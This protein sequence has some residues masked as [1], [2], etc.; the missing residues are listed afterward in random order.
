M[1]GGEVG[2]GDD[3]VRRLESGEL[4]AVLAEQ[5]RVV[6]AS[7]LSCS[8]VQENSQQRPL[9]S[10]SLTSLPAASSALLRFL[11]FFAAARS[12]VSG[13]E[14]PKKSSSEGRLEPEATGPVGFLGCVWQ[15]SGCV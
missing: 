5:G 3:G 7:N 13:C 14:V 2:E 1:G 12:L 9:C 15:V 10:P 11:L 6:H 4:D 8:Y